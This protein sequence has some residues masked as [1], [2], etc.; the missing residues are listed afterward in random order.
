M[1]YVDSYHFYRLRFSGDVDDQS[2]DFWCDLTNSNAH[3]I[4]WCA[5]EGKVLT[6]PESIAKLIGDPLSHIEEVTK[7]A[8]PVPPHL[9][10]GVS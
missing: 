7:T 5:Q 3:A 10:S 6:P 8:K 2:A 4:G 9:L 1:L